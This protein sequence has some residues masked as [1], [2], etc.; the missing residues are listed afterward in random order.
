MPIRPRNMQTNW[1][2]TFM[3]VHVQKLIL[4]NIIYLMIK[5]LSIILKCWKVSGL[6]VQE[7]ASNIEQVVRVVCYGN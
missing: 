3:S 6:F 7:F 1:T 4:L 2:N 5:Y